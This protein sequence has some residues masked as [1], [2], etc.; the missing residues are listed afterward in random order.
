M[1]FP[2]LRQ[3]RRLF[4]CITGGVIFTSSVLAQTIYIQPDRA[5][6]ERAPGAQVDVIVSLSAPIPNGLEGYH[7]R[8]RHPEDVFSARAILVEV[9]ELDH[10]LLEGPADRYFEV[11]GTRIQGFVEWGQPA[12]P[13]TSFLVF[14][15]TVSADVGPGDYALALELP[16]DNCFINGLLESVDDLLVLG[17]ATLRISGVADVN[18]NGV[19]DDWELQFYDDLDDVPPTVTIQGYEFSI[20]EMYIAGLDPTGDQIPAFEHPDR[21]VSVE[22]RVYDIFFNA[23]LL[24]PAGWQLIAT[25]EGTGGLLEI[26]DSGPGAYRYVVRLP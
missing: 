15:F 16:E 26:P 18:G 24:N 10:G 14:Q 12:Y 11:D 2:L 4:F 5:V 23:N 8:L 1:L 17:S 3:C 21:F 7:I 20:L 25:L 9:P 13:G 6:Y 22:G 19:P